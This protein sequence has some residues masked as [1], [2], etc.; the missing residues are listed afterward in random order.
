MHYLRSFVKVYSGS[1]ARE[2]G[3]TLAQLVGERAQLVGERAQ[4]V[5][6]NVHSWSENRAQLVG[7]PCTVGRKTALLHSWSG[8]VH[9]WSD[10]NSLKKRPFVILTWFASHALHRS[11]AP[12]KTF[13]AVVF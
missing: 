11:V 7:K 4:L 3:E 6:K 10:L 1:T 8:L 12:F 13:I 2:K 9:S 5:G